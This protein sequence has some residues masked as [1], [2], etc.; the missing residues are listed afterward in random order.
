MGLEFL[1]FPQE[2][3]RIIKRKI[4]PDIFIDFHCSEYL[5]AESYFSESNDSLKN[6]QTFNDRKLIIVEVKLLE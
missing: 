1:S 3:K 5:S 6:L 4:E 2:T